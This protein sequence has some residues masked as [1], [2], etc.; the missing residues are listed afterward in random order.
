MGTL[1]YYGDVIMCAI[2]S[3]ITSLTIV[4]STVFFRRRSKKEIKAPCHWPLC[5]DF[6][7]QMASTAENV[8][9]WWRHNLETNFQSHMNFRYIEHLL[10]LTP[11]TVTN[12]QHRL[13]SGSN[14]LTVPM[15]TKLYDASWRHGGYTHWGM[16][17]IPAI[18]QIFFI[19]LGGKFVYVN[20][21]FTK[22]SL[23]S[24]WQ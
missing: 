2:A 11:Q 12:D 16:D 3:Q 24:S 6:P 17:K 5:G 9:I 7:T 15:S 8:S 1:S 19:L 21:N 10:C 14:A 22:V 18:L 13:L 20:W 4:Y 23:R